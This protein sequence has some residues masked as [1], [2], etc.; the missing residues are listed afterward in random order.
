VPI[1]RYATPVR[2]RT[3][4]AHLRA[5]LRLLAAL[6]VAPLLV[7]LLAGDLVEAGLFGA[8]ALVALLA[9][10][11]PPPDPIEPK[12]ALAVTGLCYPLLALAG[13]V[14]FLPRLGLLDGFFESLSGFTTTGLTVVRPQ[15]LPASLLF[16][17]AYAQWIGG[18]GIVLL[19]LL[20]LPGAGRAPLRLFLSE[21]VE[22]ERP[23]SVGDTVRAV[24]RIY[25]VL[26]AAGFLLLLASGVPAFEAL[27]YALAGLSTGGFSPH[28]DSAAAVPGAARAVLVLL[29][30][31]GATC[32]PLYTRLRGGGWRR[33]AADAQARALLLVIAGGAALL[34]A[35]GG[36]PGRA[37]FH[38]ASAAT[39]TGFALTEPATWSGGGK[40][41]AIVLM[42]IGGA[43]GSTAGG[44]KLLRVLVLAR[45]AYWL[46]LR[47]LLPREAEPPRERLAGQG[48]PWMLAGF[49][50]LY[51]GVLLAGAL[52][53]AA[54]GHAAIDALFESASALGTVGL[55]TGITSPDLAPWAKLVLAFEMWAGRLE[56]LPVL[57][58]C[59][60]RT[61]MRGRRVP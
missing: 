11:R 29:M 52:A 36:P 57:L 49:V 2:L 6:W 39:T 21:R 37:L 33:L 23:G 8:V 31:L 19:A 40:L 13:A 16:F 7:A 14:A 5:V 20:L 32:F 59:Y 1:S 22:E 48:E 25:A 53:L 28:A 42:V 50:A 56:I 24:V 35:C 10:R 30:L 41:G 45:I 43:A 9:G 61:W 15:A 51:A 12:E 44:I 54:G 47:H 4:G 55:S 38:A 46:V 60:P 34:F 3:V 18:A 17:R 27:L 26:T 58:V